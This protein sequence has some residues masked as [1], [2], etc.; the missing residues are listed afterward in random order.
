MT[1]TAWSWSR[2]IVALVSSLHCLCRKRCVLTAGTQECSTLAVR[3]R[4]RQRAF[5][6]ATRC[7]LHRPS[8]RFSSLLACGANALSL[9]QDWVVCRQFCQQESLGEVVGLLG[10]W[11]VL[12][13]Y[14]AFVSCE[15]GKSR[16]DFV[17]LVRSELR[18]FRAEELQRARTAFCTLIAHRPEPSA[19]LGLTNFSWSPEPKAD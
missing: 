13:E 15:G 1:I 10:Y 7:H 14:E 3:A 2:F 8:C 17:S 9:L 4:E 5:Q 11:G 12:P 6:S 16:V 19:R 18:L